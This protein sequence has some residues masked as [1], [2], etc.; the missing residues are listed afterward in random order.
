MSFWRGKKVLVTGGAG[1]IGSHLCEAL[2]A[3]GAEVTI[4]T[5]Y[6]SRGVAGAVDDMPK[7]TRAALRIIMGDLKDPAGVDGAVASQ[8]V[9][10]HLAAHIGIPYSYVHPLDVMQTNAIGTAHV[11]EACRRHSV[12]KLVAFST[13]EVYGSAIYAPIDEAHPLQPQSPYAASKVAADALALSYWRSFGTPVA[14]C[15][16]F[17]TFGPRQPAR[18]VLPTIIA[19]ALSRDRISLGALTPTRDFLFV[20]DTVEGAIRVAESPDTLGEVVNLGTGIEITIGE[21]AAAILRVIGRDLP[22]ETDEMRIRPEK[23][24]V[25]RLIADAR[26]G[27]RLLGWRPTTSFEHGI[28]ATVDWVRRHPGFLV[29]GSYHV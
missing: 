7:T 11:L 5:R 26:K 15:R 22:I 21:A 19:Q 3:R 1:F 4:F 17:N 18:A 10:F 2:L 24:E 28:A 27:E 6:S 25:V 29:Q 12:S 23:S 9:V 8:E 13:S 16:P 14:L 20:V